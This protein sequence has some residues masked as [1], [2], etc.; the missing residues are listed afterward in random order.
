V[1]IYFRVQPTLQE[2]LQLKVKAVR[3]GEEGLVVLP[4]LY[5][6]PLQ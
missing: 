2:A 4:V 5:Q 3:L 1:Y 6:Q